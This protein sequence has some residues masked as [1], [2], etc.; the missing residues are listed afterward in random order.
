MK[1]NY[2]HITTLI[3]LFSIITILLQY[4]IY[5]FME[6]FSLVVCISALVCLLCT[7]IL[8]G[9]TRNYGSCFSYSL[10]NILLCSIV[11]LLSYLGKQDII[12]FEEKQYSFLLINWLVPFAY[13]L[14]RYLFDRREKYVSFRTY[15]RNSNLVFGIF[16]LIIIIKYLLLQNTK[17]LLIDVDIQT[18]NVIPFYTLATL[19]ENYISGHGNLDIICTYFIQGVLPFI[20]Y[21]Y[22][23]YLFLRYQ[24]KYLRLVALLALPF[25]IEVLQ[26]TLVLG[27]ATIEDLFLGL[28]GGII[29]G[30]LYHS[31]NTIHNKTKERDFL[32]EQIP[33]S[34][35][36]NYNPYYRF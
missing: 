10:L 9:L 22:F 23:I 7:H 5:Y 35:L 36:R 6:S 26:W 27:Q 4:V 15:Y 14:S 32:E 20:P 3:I 8:L 21:G 29:G 25:V 31:I 13:C 16:Y 33:F 2:S 18:I 12:L 11:L 30:I 28:F 1:K 24:S 19:I 17:L 34:F